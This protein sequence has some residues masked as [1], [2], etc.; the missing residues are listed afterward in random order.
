M[1]ERG[2]LLC[3]PRFDLSEFHSFAAGSIPFERVIDRHADFP[4][5]ANVA[6]ILVILDHRPHCVNDIGF[7]DFEARFF[8]VVEKERDIPRLLAG[9]FPT[10]PTEKMPHSFACDAVAGVVVVLCHIVSPLPELP[11]RL[12]VI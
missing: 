4:L 3:R 6:A 11:V 2:R 10:E 12:G 9:E 1:T 7:V 8:V 5:S